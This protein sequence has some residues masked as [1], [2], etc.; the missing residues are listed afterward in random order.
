MG[1]HRLA[2]IVPTCGRARDLAACLRSIAVGAGPELAQVIVVDDAPAA[3]AQVPARLAGAEVRVRRNAEPIGAAA[4]RNRA[5]AMLDPEIDAVGFLDD[6]VRLPPEWFAVARR[7]LTPARGAIT[8]PIRG[9]DTGL[10]SRA[11][12]LRYD[13]RYRPLLPHQDVDFLA[14]GNAVLWRRTLERAGEFQEVATMSDTLLAR[15]LREL[16]TPC[17]FVPELLVMHRNS[18]GWAQACLAAWQ[19]GAVEGRRRPTRYGERLAGGAREALDSPD[20]T[21][22]AVNVALDSVFLTAHALTRASAAAVVRRLEAPQPPPL[23]ESVLE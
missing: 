17:H 23:A 15:R 9:F 4:S 8:G 13:A 7:E 19:A 14:G 21:A 1:D 2:L 22:A 20:P 18:K 3:P 12:Q 5:L 10:V 11:R 16:G 6:D